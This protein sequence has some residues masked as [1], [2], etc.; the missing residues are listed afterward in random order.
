M[1]LNFLL[2]LNHIL[3]LASL[4]LHAVLGASFFWILLAHLTCRRQAL[5]REATLL[6]AP[7]PADQPHVLVQLPTFNEGKLIRRL[8]ARVGELDWPR[9]RL[10]IQI[11]DDSTDGSEAHAK[12]A[13]AALQ[14]A[15]LDAMVLHRTD[16]TGFKAGA[17]ANG[18][19]HS[20]SDFVAILDADYLP[21]P[22][23]LALC[24]RPFLTD[25]KLAL[26][27]ARCD[28]LNGDETAITRAQRRILDA[29]YAIEQ[30]A[31]NWSGQVMPFN[32]TCGV[33]R[34][35]ALDQAGDW[36]G[37]TLAEDMDVSYRAQ[38]MG[39]RTLFLATVAVPGELP[40]S[41]GDWRRQQFRWT[42]GS[43]QVGRKIL[44]AVW[45]SRL[46]L[47]QKIGASFHLGMGAF[48][49]LLLVVL[50]TGLVESLW[51]GGLSRPA[52]AM[53]ALVA[54]EMIAGPALLQLAG[55]RLVRK[56][57]LFAELF[58]VPVVLVLQLLVGLANLRGSVEALA[59]RHSAFVRTA[60]QGA[61]DQALGTE[62]K[63]P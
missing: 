46:S 51:G 57:N 21:P 56:A 33:W 63:A 41:F 16:R 8:A 13:A 44:P 34:R 48:G 15:G 22:D 50:A 47:G 25:A 12:A 32:G 26:V 60:K 6:A 55:Q 23:F 14:S 38:M 5:A 59:G 24:L 7:L 58:Q 20:T 2:N 40:R 43:A 29:H 36:Q 31:R 52:E 10:H 3:L 42:K 49:P 19:L 1:P 27:Q 35:A 54:L 45:R 9:D 18:L 30:P 17:L 28:Y 53:I 11:L 37:D 4:A 39:W 61:L 62:A